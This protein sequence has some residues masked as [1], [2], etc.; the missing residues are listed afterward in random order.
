MR[1]KFSLIRDFVEIA[2]LI[3]IAHY[4]FTGSFSKNLIQSA[5][6]APTLMTGDITICTS[7]VRA[8]RGD[9]IQF[10]NE[11]KKISNRIIGV[12]GDVITFSKDGYLVL[13][14]VKQDEKYVMSPGT[15]YPVLD[16][17]YTVPSGKVFVMGDN[18]ADSNDSRYWD[19]PYV[20]VK[21]INGVYLFTL[22][23]AA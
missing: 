16:E 8:D 15:T 11:D 9:I 5:S 22:H 6:M 10:E 20:D 23:H 1:K 4:I 14:G 18:R 2:I 21:D 12:A 17:T 3:L 19:E 13:N 7:L